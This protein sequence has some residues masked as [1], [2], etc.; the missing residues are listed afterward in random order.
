VFNYQIKNS[1]NN[2]NELKLKLKNIEKELNAFKKK[3]Y[4]QK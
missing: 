3:N 1:I 2:N 4:N